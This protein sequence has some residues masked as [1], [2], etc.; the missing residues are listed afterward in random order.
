M[1]TVY[2]KLTRGQ[3]C[4]FSGLCP[5]DR[6]LIGDHAVGAYLTL[7]PEFCFVCENSSD[8][9]IVAYVVAASDAKA[10]HSRYHLE[11]LPA[12]RNKYPRKIVDTTPNEVCILEV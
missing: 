9:T 11:W 10:F 7:S 12:M 8:G 1:G 4:L 5:S 3:K 2:K 6:V